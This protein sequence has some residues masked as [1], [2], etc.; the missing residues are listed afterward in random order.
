[1][2][3]YLTAAP[4]AAAGKYARANRE[5][6][7]KMPGESCRRKGGHCPKREQSFPLRN[8]FMGSRPIPK[9]I[10]AKR[11]RRPAEHRNRAAH[12]PNDMAPRSSE[13]LAEGAHPTLQTRKTWR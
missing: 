2:S 4:E 13:P 1:M 8:D 9:V 11:S 3:K 7:K 5:Q 12:G 6:P 10:V